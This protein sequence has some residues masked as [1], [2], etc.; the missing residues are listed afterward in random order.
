MKTRYQSPASGPVARAPSPAAG[1][2]AE[3][4]GEADQRAAGLRGAGEAGEGEHQEDDAAGIADAPGDIGDPADLFASDE[5][6]QHGVVEDDRE[7][8]GDLGK[9]DGGG[10]IKQRRAGRGEEPDQA[11]G[12]DFPRPQ[13]PPIQGFRGPAR[14]AIEPRIG[15]RIAT[16]RPVTVA[17]PLHQACPVAGSGA[18]CETKYGPKTKVRTTVKKGWAAKSK[19][20]QPQ[21][22]GR[23]RGSRNGGASGSVVAG[24]APAASAASAGP[25]VSSGQRSLN[26]RRPRRG[27]RP[28][29]GARRV[30]RAGQGF[31]PQL[32]R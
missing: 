32:Q 13:S 29:R 6:R 27:R 26:G 21:T 7:L 15:E 8:G 19:L 12:R 3:E 14:S 24:A 1:V 18:S 4:R 22:A 16:R 5:A 23:F 31:R 17:A 25:A 28:A 20:I 30:R 10:R 11:Q 2:E 9:D